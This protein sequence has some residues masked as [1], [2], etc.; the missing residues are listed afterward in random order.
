MRIAFISDI[1]ANLIALE[2]VLADLRRER[3]D[4]TICLGDVVNLGARPREVLAAIKALN[5]PCILGNHDALMM[6]PRVANGQEPWVLEVAAWT[7][8]QLTSEDL[9][10]LRSFQPTLQLT[11]DDEVSLLCCHG[12]P[13]SFSDFL[14]ATT[15]EREV[16][17]MLDGKQASVMACGHTHVQMMRQFFGMLIVNAGSVGQPFETMP[18]PISQA[19]PHLLP[20]AE[21]AILETGGCAVKVELRHL[22]VDVAAIKQVALASGMPGAATW[23]SRWRAPSAMRP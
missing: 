16:Q 4:L 8:D 19:G 12:S 23:V 13:R 6:D 22:E 11:L 2:T 1:H 17:W 20:W 10:F 7:L 5:C 21:Y 3:V 9:A 18:W 14:L 15:P